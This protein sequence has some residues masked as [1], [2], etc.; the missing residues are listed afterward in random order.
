MPG[1]TCEATV[2]D[3]YG[4]LSSSICVALGNYHNMNRE[5]KTIAAE[6]IDVS[7]WENMVKL[8]IHLARTGH[9]YERGFKALKGRIEKNFEALQHLLAPGMR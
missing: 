6:Y 3:I 1:G 4:Y 2:Y 8:F 9:T 5:K 7:D